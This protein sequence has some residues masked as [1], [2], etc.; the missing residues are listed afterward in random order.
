MLVMPQLIKP[1]KIH[2]GCVAEYE[3]IW[4]NCA[5]LIDVIE[6]EANDPDSGVV[7]NKAAT[8]G[9]GE[10]DKRR[11]NKHLG[12]SKTAEVN[13]PLREI[14]N[15]FYFTLA[16]VIPTYR[17]MFGLE[18]ELYMTEGFNLLRYQTGQEYKAHF[19]GGT[20][21]RRSVSPILY[22]NDDYAGGELEFVNHNLKIKPKAGSL[23][24]FPS[25]Y[26]YRHIAHPVVDGTKYAIVT[27]LHD[28][29]N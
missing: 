6:Q 7:F 1:T 4:T 5:E 21:T 24:L 17:E 3:N 26:P 10:F 18:E 20:A 23:F 9:G 22:L 12:L 28:R 16:S 14:N 13:E 15:K 25:S 8:Q 29:L 2:A 27:W 19:D 11:T